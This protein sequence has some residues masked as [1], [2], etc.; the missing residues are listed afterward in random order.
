MS[1]RLSGHPAD[2]AIASLPAGLTFPGNWGSLVDRTRT[3]WVGSWGTSFASNLTPDVTTGL[4]SWTED[5]FVQTIRNGKHQGTGRKLLP[6]MP[7]ENIRQLTDGD[8]KA[9]WAFLQSLPAVENAV[10]DPLPTGR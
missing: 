1:L 7:W 6:P 2:S 9:I 5:M 8:L 4:G 10:P 3:A